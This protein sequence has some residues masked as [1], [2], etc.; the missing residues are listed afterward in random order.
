MLE[1]LSL[2]IQVYAFRTLFIFPFIE[3]ANNQKV[4][5]WFYIS[6]TYNASLSWNFQV[7]SRPFEM[8][9]VH[10]IF[11]IDITV[12]AGLYMPFDKEALFKTECTCY[13][14][15]YIVI[16]HATEEK[17]PLIYKV[18]EIKYLQ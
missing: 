13:G 15:N 16:H 9:S 12:T 2:I 17:N 8:I 18:T 6:I 14:H 3:S 7:L 5:I 4:F 11:P 10:C 1:K